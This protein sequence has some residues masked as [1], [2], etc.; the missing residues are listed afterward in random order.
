MQRFLIEIPHEA[1]P[2]ACTIAVRPREYGILLLTNVTMA[3]V[4]DHRLVD[5]GGERQSRGRRPPRIAPE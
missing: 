3:A 2:L 4:T 1:D 5:S